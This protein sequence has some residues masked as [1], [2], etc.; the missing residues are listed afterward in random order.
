MQVQTPGNLE[1]RPLPPSPAC[2]RGGPGRGGGLGEDLPKQVLSL[3]L[4]L[5]KI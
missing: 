5:V 2:P 4:L 1:P 3:T